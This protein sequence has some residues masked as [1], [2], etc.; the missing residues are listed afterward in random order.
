MG[1]GRCT[2]WEMGGAVDGRWEVHQMGDGRCSRWEMGGAPNGRWEV[3]D[4]RRGDGE[5]AEEEIEARG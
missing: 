2:K 1:D 4:G 3:G 5:A